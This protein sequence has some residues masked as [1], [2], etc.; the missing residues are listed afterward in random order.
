VTW[1]IEP[2]ARTL[3]DDSCEFGERGRDVPMTPGFDAEFVVTAPN[4]LHE[5]VTADDHAGG[6]VAFESAHRSESG[7][8]VTMVCFDP[9]VR[10]LP[11]VVKRARHE[12]LDHRAERGRPVGH[13]LHWL[14][15]YAERGLEEPSCRSRVASR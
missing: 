2:R 1:E 6:V 8:Q 5:C 9:I 7:F 4:V 11:G 13:D 15:V 10:I 12:F 14:A 3:L